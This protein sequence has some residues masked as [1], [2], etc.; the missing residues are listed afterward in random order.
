MVVSTSSSA[1]SHWGAA[2]RLG[3]DTLYS[4]GLLEA[5]DAA[6]SR[7]TIHEGMLDRMALWPEV[8]AAGEP[9]AAHADTEILERACERTLARH[10]SSTRRPAVFLDR[11]G[12]LVVERE[13][14]SDPDDLELLPGVPDALKAMRNAGYALV[15]VSNQSGVGRGYFSLARAYETMA[16]LRVML[17]RHRVEFDAIYFCPHR[18]D[19][20]CGCRKPGTLLLERA[21]D[22][23]QLRLSS[24]AMVGDKLLDVATAQRAGAVGVLVR[25]GY[26]DAEAKRASA[27]ES[28]RPDHVADDLHAAADWIV[29]LGESI[30]S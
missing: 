5:E 4:Y 25:T 24:S 12:T 3:W 23:L 16:R 11:D 7:A 9:D 10:R 17:R 20:H 1:M 26:G 15:L 8:S 19:E 30:P 27:D 14:L 6:R 2:N 28:V 22:D 13:Y 21:E 18:P 29:R